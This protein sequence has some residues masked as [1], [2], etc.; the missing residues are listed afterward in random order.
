MGKYKVLVPTDFT[1]VADCAVDHAVGIAKKLNGEVYLLHI[2]SSQKDVEK[3][4]PKLETSASNHSQK[5]GIAIHPII[6]IG[7]IFE[8][9]GDVAAE[10]NAHLIVMG[11]HGL[12]GIQY[13]LG[14]NALKVITHSKVPFVVVQEKFFGGGYDHIVAPIDYSEETKQKLTIIANMARHFNSKVHILVPKEKD[15]FLVAKLNRD[16]SFAKNYLEEKGVTYHIQYAE[17]NT[18]FSKQII[19]YASVL[20]NS[21]IVIVN[22]PDQLLLPGVLSGNEEQVIIANDSMIP[23]LIMNPS[24]EFLPSNVLFS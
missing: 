7:N 12:K 14:S 19:R 15:E 18:K 6:R 22:S 11:T 16:L 20:N 8:D 23:V 5:Y 21:L 2:V 13:L 17:D 4:Q 9:I 3:Y 10:I 24:Q 1:K